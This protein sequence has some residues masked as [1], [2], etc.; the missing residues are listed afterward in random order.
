MIANIQSVHYVAVHK[1]TNQYYS[2]LISPKPDTKPHKLPHETVET[3]RNIMVHL[4][5]R[6]LA[7]ENKRSYCS[8]LMH[9]VTLRLETEQKSY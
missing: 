8:K 7:R 5:V 1:N 2:K 4:F 9:L 3:H 6:L